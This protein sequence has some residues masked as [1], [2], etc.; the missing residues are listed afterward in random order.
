[1]EERMMNTSGTYSITAKHNGMVYVGSSG[2][3]IEQRWS[4]HKCKLRSRTHG[5]KHLQNVFDKHGEGCFVWEVVEFCGKEEVLKREAYWI[6]K[7]DSFHNGYNLVEEP[8]GGGMRGY[9][10]TEETLEKMRKPTGIRTRASFEPEQVRVL[11]QKYFDGARASDLAKES[12]VGVQATRK[13]LRY[14]TYRDIEISGEYEKM[15]A[16]E[17]EERAE[18][19]NIRSRGW[20]HKPEFLT[21]LKEIN[22]MPKH[23]IRRLSSQQVREIRRR[24]EAGELTIKLAA[25]FG[26]ANS[27]ISNIVNRVHYAEIE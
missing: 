4:Q 22:S 10:H 8:T 13:M 20:K 17:E 16:R 23:H 18:G 3:S 26:V 14:K 25:E 11:R 19:K 5:N 12:G 1:V 21:K 2:V 15:L 27:T 6:K 24:K 7:F 9:R